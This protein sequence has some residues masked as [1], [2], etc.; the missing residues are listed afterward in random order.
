MEGDKVS[1]ILKTLGFRDADEV[2]TLAQISAI[3]RANGTDWD[4]A[5]RKHYSSY[6]GGSG[7]NNYGLKSAFDPNDY[8][9]IQ[10]QHERY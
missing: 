6:Y 9:L 1:K 10:Q 2:R 7:V 8:E 3:K 4:A 5:A